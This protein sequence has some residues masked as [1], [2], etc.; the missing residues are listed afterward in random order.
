MLAT[1]GNSMGSSVVIKMK[2]EKC[3]R[4]LKV[5]DFVVDYCREGE[6]KSKAGSYGVVFASNHLI[7][8]LEGR[9]SSKL[10]GLEI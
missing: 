1:G 8:E 10:L 4:E 9:T 5:S 3:L 6:A 2:I 7:H